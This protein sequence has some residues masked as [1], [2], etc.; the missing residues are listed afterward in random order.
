MGGGIGVWRDAPGKRVVLGESRHRG[1]LKSPTSTSKVA[2]EP[3]RLSVVSFSKEQRLK[4]QPRTGK[5]I[6]LPSQVDGQTCSALI[7]SGAAAK[8]LIGED[9]AQ[10]IKVPRQRLDRPRECVAFNNEVTRVTSFVRVR[11]TI[12]AA[13][14]EEVSALVVPKLSKEVI[15][16]IPWLEEHDPQISWQRRAVALNSSY[17][18]TKCLKPNKGEDCNVE[19][20]NSR[21]RSVKTAEKLAA[22]R[23]AYC[24]Q[25]IRTVDTKIDIGIVDVEE[26]LKEL[27][28]PVN[29]VFQVEVHG[30]R[31]ECNLAQKSEED[32]AK[33]LRDKPPPDFRKL[34]PH[35]GRFRKLFCPEEAKALPPLRPG[36][37]HDIEL[38]REAKLPNSRLYRMS[39]PELEVL[40]KYI[41]ENLKKGYIRP[42]SSP[43][44]SPVLFVKKPSGGLRL[45]V[46]YR[47]LNEVTIKDRT[48]LPLTDESF[49]RLAEA[50]YFTKVDVIAAFNK[51]RMKEGKEWLTAFRTRFGLFEYAV[52]PFG[53]TNAPSSFTR[54]LNST[55]GMDILAD[56]ANTHSDDILIFSRTQE[57]HRQHVTQV[58]EK[59]LKEGLYL[60]LEKSEFG[61][62][63]VK[64]LGHVLE[65][66]KGI[67]ADP[68]KIDAVKSWRAPTSVKEVR[69]FLGFV[70]YYRR[71]VEGFSRIAKPLTDL[72]RTV[73]SGKGKQ[74]VWS[75]AAQEAFEELKK[76][77]VEAPIL[78]IFDPKKPCVV[79][80][81]ASNFAS[82]GVLKQPGGKEGSDVEDAKDDLNLTSLFFKSLRPVAFFSSKH[83]DTETRYDA[84]DKEL[85]AV[86]KAFK[87]WRSELEGS[88]RIQVLS[89]HKNLQY[90]MK[91]RV[92]NDR[93]ARWMEF[94]SRFDFKIRYIPGRE[95]GEADALSRR[96]QD[97]DLSDYHAPTVALP[98][99]CF[100]PLPINPIDEEEEPLEEAIARGYREATA[101]DPVR[102]I[103][104]LIEQG[105]R[106][107]RD[108]PLADCT[109]DGERVKFRRHRIWVPESEDLRRRVIEEH[110]NPPLVGHP[111]NAGT[112]AR[113]AGSFYW[114]NMIQD[115]RRYIR[116]CH[117]CQRSKPSHERAGQLLPLPVPQQRWEDITMDFITD[118]PMAKKSTLCKNATSILVVVDRLSKEEHI[119]PC[120]KMTAAYL[121][122]IFVRDVV[123]LHGLPKSIVTDRGT[124]FT[125]ELWK[126]VCRML[127]MKQSLTSAFHPQSDGQSERTNQDVEQHLRRLVNYAQDDWPEW[128]WILE[129][130][131]N[132]APK[133]AI[134][135][136]SSFKATRGFNPPHT[137]SATTGE[138]PARAGV[139][140]DLEGPMR[141]ILSDIR[142]NLAL[143]RQ[144]MAD[145]AGGSPPPRLQR[146]D[147]VWLSTKNLRSRQQ[148]PKLDDKWVG[149]FPIERVVNERAYRLRLPP[150]LK[151]HPTFHVG[152]LKLALSD[153]LAGQ[154]N[155][156]YDNPPALTDG[157]WEVERIVDLVRR[158]NGWRYVVK[159]TGWPSEHNTEEP[160]D[161]LLP[162][163]EGAL[164]EF[165][166]RTGKYTAARRKRREDVA[167]GPRSLGGG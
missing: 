114:P 102:R 109:M 123:R 26:F 4:E 124:Q 58:F 62:Q 149:P 98:K 57:E 78:A 15:L 6:Y 2:G 49:A 111:G 99:S 14:E 54:L 71:F 9:L 61:V 32:I 13:H 23:K 130:A 33:A 116:N 36:L 35:L 161:N 104:E 133:A 103:P 76:R 16:G 140:D 38:V 42:S 92:L 64:F 155:P 48:T 166:A 136:R 52:M 45:C 5:C 29:E 135:G 158:G 60:D 22:E 82:G 95:N 74:F 31:V 121:A 100:E 37:D 144:V 152:L 160:L 153:P 156:E 1:P 139:L 143:T 81:D 88:V 165:E 18:R 30:E 146:G 117:P 10:K 145:S 8:M 157:V 134:G 120:E 108:L 39:Q 80:T 93:Q 118:L 65:A 127:G 28:D 110:H 63:K 85:L 53:L 41:D 167:R 137:Q 128:C 164:R 125:S 105:V 27:E 69:S 90:F 126:E 73:D 72:T 17:C 154:R 46:D 24:E 34:P 97:G 47:K 112:Y 19:V 96:G 83:S 40:R 20:D 86:V 55:L 70:N 43:V 87:E 89:D 25:G 84:H 67:S 75:D 66:G 56:S 106:K 132:S 12:N 68:E 115:V 44:A 151:V 3:I 11:L 138:P 162:D 21:R 59:L 91:E 131:R 119:I 148:S 147:M 79:I 159:W 141:E 101:E 7:D 94:L 122:N 142:D 113:I 107:H 163:A 77:L 129:F 51:L 150:W 50:R